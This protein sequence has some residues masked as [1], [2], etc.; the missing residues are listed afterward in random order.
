M[1]PPNEP[2][3]EVMGVEEV[4][5]MPGDNAVLEGDILESALSTV[6]DVGGFETGQRVD[7]LCQVVL[8]SVGVA[9]PETFGRMRLVEL[10]PPHREIEIP[11]SL[12][13]ASY[14][15]ATSNKV[16]SVRPLSHQLFLEVMK[17][18]SLSLEL[19]VI[20]GR[21]R[22]NYLAEI[23]MTSPSVPTKRFPARP[24]DAV[25]LAEAQT[26]PIPIMV[27]S[28]LFDGVSGD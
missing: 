11:I 27:D 2:L 15:S 16:N 20:S 3:G 14:L 17:A 23:T 22:G 12:E 9:L 28:L 7:R 18:F 21:D 26:P 1:N 8:R 10:D 25:I 19:V 13:M 5:K 24:S 6:G 4:E